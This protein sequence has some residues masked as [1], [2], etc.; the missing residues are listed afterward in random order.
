MLPLQDSRQSVWNLLL[1]AE[2]PTDTDLNTMSQRFRV[3][4]EAECRDS[5]PLYKRLALG[6]AADEELLR[7]AAL[8]PPGQPRPNLLLGAVHFLLLQNPAEPLVSFYPDLSSSPGS[9]AAAYPAFRDFCL[10]HR[11]QIVEI[12]T[13]RRVQTNEVRRCSYLYPAFC[14]IARCARSCPL[15]LIEI[16]TS[17][18]LNLLWDRYTYW[19]HTQERTMHAG[20]PQSQVQIHCELRGP[21]IPPLPPETPT[22][23]CRVGIDLNIVDLKDSDQALW[24]RALIWPEHTERVQLLARAIPILQQAQLRLLTGDALSRLPELFRTIPWEAALVIFHTHTL[25]QFTREARE[26]LTCLISQEARKREVYRLG[27]DLGP[28]EPNR[29]PLMFHEY[30]NGERRE[31]HLANVAPHGNWMEWLHSTRE[32]STNE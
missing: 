7:L 14:H 17:A 21:H 1:M 27:N 8:S 3:F 24:L 11:E 2:Q 10:S 32:R 29:F 19:Y 4:A 18:G 22:V 26:E 31:H 30:C 12:I 5:S 13:R 15:A 9:P 28:G 25:N 23:A 6:I 20:D 16:G